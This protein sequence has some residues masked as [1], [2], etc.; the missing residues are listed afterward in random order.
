M[1]AVVAVLVQSLQHGSVHT[2]VAALDWVLHLYTRLPEC[3]A[4]QTERVFPVC[5]GR[6]TD[7]ADDV[8]RRALAVL[9]DISAPS[10]LHRAR[11]LQAL[12]RL[13]AADD[14]P[15]DRGAFIVRQLCVLLGA[16]DVYGAL[17]DELETDTNPTFV[18]GAVTV[19]N[20]L[21]LTAAELHELRGRLRAFT[22]PAV[23]ALFVRLYRCW[24]HSPVSLVCLCLLTRNYDH[25]RLLLTLLYPLY[26]IHMLHGTHCVT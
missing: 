4:V 5:V 24:S 2:K 16:D 23:R 14:A 21:L 6:L 3:M 20:T 8:V 7:P 26:Y 18:S 13:L 25:C 12:R 11:L 1:A 15:E 22:T 9:A 10:E 19:L 17:A